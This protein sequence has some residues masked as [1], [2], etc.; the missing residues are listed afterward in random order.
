MTHFPKLVS[1]A[2]NWKMA[3]QF[4]KSQCTQTQTLKLDTP[5]QSSGWPIIY[6]PNTSHFKLKLVAAIQVGLPE[7]R[8]LH[9]NF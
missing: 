2:P 1:F 6:I 8:T 9:K 7:V 5:N 4:L 3:P